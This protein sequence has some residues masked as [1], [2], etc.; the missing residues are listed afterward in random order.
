MLHTVQRCAIC[1]QFYHFCWGPVSKESP[2]EKCQGRYGYCQKREVNRVARSNRGR[3]PKVVELQYFGKEAK[4]ERRPDD[5]SNTLV[6]RLNTKLLI[7]VTNFDSS[8]RLRQLRPVMALHCRSPDRC[9]RC[10]IRGTEGHTRPT[11]PKTHRARSVQSVYSVGECSS[12]IG[13]CG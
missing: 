3:Q 13:W 6:D 12:A 10:R 11:K 1:Q 7:K 4:K 8:Q 2:A 5:S 9:K